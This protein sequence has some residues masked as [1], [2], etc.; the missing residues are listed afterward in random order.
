MIVT[1]SKCTHVRRTVEA[2]AANAGTFLIASEA[3]F[4]ALLRRSLEIGGERVIME[5]GK[6]YSWLGSLRHRQ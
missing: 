6:G 1:G 3:A 4:F 5:I 2:E